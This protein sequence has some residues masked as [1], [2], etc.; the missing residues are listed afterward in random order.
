MPGSA[1]PGGPLPPHWFRMLCSFLSL[2]PGR[3]CELSPSA[4]LCTAGALGPVAGGTVHPH[5]PAC[6]P[7]AEQ[8]GRC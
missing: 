7:S 2:Q 5:P 1:A 6:R 4:A 8:T 3:F